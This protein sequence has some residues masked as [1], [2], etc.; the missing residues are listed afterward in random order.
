MNPLKLWL[1]LLSREIEDADSR[2][3]DSPHVF[4]T[5]IMRFL[6]KKEA[7]HLKKISDSSAGAITG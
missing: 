2:G 3:V 6:G 1:T 4:A 5:L 7:K